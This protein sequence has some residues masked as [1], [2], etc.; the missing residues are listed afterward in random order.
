MKNPSCVEMKNHYSQ[1]PQ[2]NNPL[3]EKK[4]KSS[5]QNY[6]IDATLKL[7]LCNLWYNLCLQCNALCAPT[8]LILTIEGI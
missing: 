6:L 8:D 2:I 7:T 3:Y 4:K 5:V 1:E